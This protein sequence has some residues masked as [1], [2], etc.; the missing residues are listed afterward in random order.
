MTEEPEERDVRYDKQIDI[1]VE[2]GSQRRKLIVSLT[3]PALA[4]SVLVSAVSMCD[5]IMVGGLGVYA[6]SA[7]GLVMQPRFIMMA[8]F[9]AMSVGTTAL[10]A[11]CKGARD[12]E[13]ANSA[14]LQSMIITL[15]LTAVI[16]IAM[17]FLCEP[18]LRW[19]GGSELSE[20]TI[21]E[22]ITYF[23][24]QIYGFP[25]LS[26]TLT[27][28]AALRGAGNTR[29]SFY[30]NTVSNIVNLCFNYCLIGGNLGFPRLEVAGASIATVFGQFVGFVM[31]VYIVVNGKEYIRLSF[32]RRWKA[33]FSM[34]KRIVNIGVPSLIEQVIMRVGTLWFTTI[35]TA[36]GDV[37]Y[38]AHMVAMNIQ[39]ISFTTGMA[40]GVAAT[41]LVGQSLGRGRADLARVY[42]RMTQNLGYIV[43]TIIAV[44]LFAF[45]KFLAGMYTADAVIIILAANMLKIIAVSNPVSN[46]RFVY[47]SALRG[48]GD[49]RFMAVITFIGV[50][51]VRPL[52]ALLL[53]N[54]FD[55]GLTGVWIALVS[56]GVICFSIALMR[57]RRGKWEY[58]SV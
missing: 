4:E 2:S 12:P 15:I 11:R 56:D 32:G 40:F 49:A 41:T 36:L 39:Q 26:F 37:S 43:S 51:L 10:V 19:L 45:G 22:S 24:I 58:I 33:D 17:T 30:T 9:M 5:M 54:I 48:A 18:L 53:I 57:Y 14:L 42:V 44:L 47:I 13:G 3:W 28:N 29:A 23:K 27:I 35:V 34:M 50:L 7:V 52:V 6:I 55:M 46:A 1:E 8:A 16:C 31:A 25:T 21:L 20:R 38:A